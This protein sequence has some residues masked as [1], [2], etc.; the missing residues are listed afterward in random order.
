MILQITFHKKSPIT[1]IAMELRS[2]NGLTFY[3]TDGYLNLPPSFPS[4]MY[5]SHKCFV[6]CLS[7]SAAL[8]T[9]PLWPE[10][11]FLTT[12]LRRKNT[13]ISRTVFG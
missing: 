2:N 3:A 10:N 5:C 8:T 13:I 1:Y 11:I 12:H 9:K 6:L 7:P 4:P